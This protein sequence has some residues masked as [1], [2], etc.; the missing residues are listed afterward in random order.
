MRGSRKSTYPTHG[1]SREILMGR[2]SERPKVKEMF[3]PKLEFPE[4]WWF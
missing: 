2:G 4:G 1:G 3:E